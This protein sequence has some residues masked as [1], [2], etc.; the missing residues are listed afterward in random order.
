MNPEY[1][2]AA[3]KVI[4]NPPRLVNVISR[5]VR[6]LNSGQRPMVDVPPRTD[7]LNIALQEVA[8]GKLAVLAP[9]AVLEPEAPAEADSTR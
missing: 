2:E 4:P 1:L 3:L 7:P 5:R 6:Q 8:A 9:G